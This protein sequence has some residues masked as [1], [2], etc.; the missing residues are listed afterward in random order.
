MKP[1]SSVKNVNKFFQ[2][3]CVL[4]DISFK[5]KNGKLWH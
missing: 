3:K 5:F 4:H 1:I 2:Q